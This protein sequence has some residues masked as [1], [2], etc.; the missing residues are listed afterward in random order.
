MAAEE[1]VALIACGT[2]P[3][4]QAAAREL[5]RRN[6]IVVL[7]GP[8]RQELQAAAERLATAARSEQVALCAADLTSA[9]DRERLV[10]FTLDEFERIDL[11]LSAWSPPQ[12]DQ[13]LLELTDQTCRAAMESCLIGPLFLIQRVGNEMVRLTEAGAI[14]SAKI[15]LVNYLAAYASLSAGAAGCLAAAAAGTLTRLLAD[16]L[17]EHGVNV[18]EV[19]AGLI[20]TG[21]GDQAQVRYDALINEGAIPIRRWGRPQDIALAVAAIAEDLL[22]YSTGQVIHV[23]GGL[24]LRKP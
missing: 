10:E 12:T 17:A 9:A 20:S 1:Q 8:S 7:G 2:D 15:V 13:D 6:W 11:L 23:D 19:R 5:V 4:G 24:H 18:Y 21:P 14:E 16:R 22:A 3:A